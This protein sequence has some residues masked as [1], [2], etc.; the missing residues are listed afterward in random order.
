M[1]E[2]INKFKTIQNHA[3]KQQ[4]KEESNDKFDKYLHSLGNRMF[5]LKTSNKFALSRSFMELLEYSPEEYSI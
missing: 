3:G 5:V 2:I 4:P 1:E